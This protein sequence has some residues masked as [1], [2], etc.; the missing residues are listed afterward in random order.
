MPNVAIPGDMEGFGVVMLEAGLSGLPVLAANIEGIRDVVEPGQNGE[1][2]PAHDAAAWVAA[3]SR[4]LECGDSRGE[5]AARTRRFTIE[6]FSWDAIARQLITG[7]RESPK[8][9]NV[10]K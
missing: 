10:R 6:H 9:K 3:I 8:T 5:V 4:A 1:L 2:L 7:F